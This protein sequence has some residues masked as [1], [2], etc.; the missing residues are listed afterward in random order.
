MYGKV[1][2]IDTHFLLYIFVI[3]DLTITRIVIM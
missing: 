3:L 1:G 2:V